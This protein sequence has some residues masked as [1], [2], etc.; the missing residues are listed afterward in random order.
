[1]KTKQFILIAWLALL[2][3]AFI[4]TA[5]PAGGKGADEQAV[6]DLDAQWAK[7]AAAKDVDKTVSFYSADAVVLPPNQAAV[8]TKD[9]IRNLWKGL[10]DSASSVSWTATR[11]EMAKSGDM[12]SV[13]GTYELAMNDGTKDRG[14][15][16]EVWEKKGGTWKCGTDIWNSDL[17]A[18]AAASAEKK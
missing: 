4:E 14:K 6:R 18:T 3:L 9:E 1:M 10:L 16:C 15:Y 2:P 5:L 7:A 12:A 17:P 11:V 13:T 8:T